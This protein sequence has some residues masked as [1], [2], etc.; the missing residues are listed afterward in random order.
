MATLPPMNKRRRTDSGY[1]RNR[2]AAAIGAKYA[3]KFPYSQYGT[4]RVPKGYA[5]A[6]IGESW[7]TAT[8]EQRAW[9]KANNYY[10]V[11]GFWRDTVWG[12][13]KKGAK[14]AWKPMA[15]AGLHAIGQGDLSRAI[16]LGAYQTGVATNA[17]V[18]PG[19]SMDVTNV[20]PSLEDDSGDIILSHKEMIANITL[21]P[22]TGQSP[23]NLQSF[24]INPGLQETFP[25]LSQIAQNFTKYKFEGLI[26]TYKPLSGEGGG[27]TNSLGKIVMATEYDP[28]AADF[29]NSTQMENS[30]Y[31]NS[32][33]PS[34]GAQ[35][36]VETA[37]SQGTSGIGMKYIR[38]GEVARDKT[39][40]DYGKFQF[41]TEAIMRES[42]QNT[43]TIIGEL[44][45]S[46]KVRLSV[47]NLYSTMLGYNIRNS[48]YD[49]VVDTNPTAATSTVT[50]VPWNV[51]PTSENVA[52]GKT[53][54][55]LKTT[56]SLKNVWSTDSY[57][58]L[59]G[60]TASQSMHTLK[61]EFPKE[62][63]LGVYRITIRQFIQDD[64][65][66]TT[67]Q[68]A[69]WIPYRGSFLAGD[70]KTR[71]CCPF[72]FVQNGILEDTASPISSANVY[73]L[74]EPI[75]PKQDG[76]GYPLL[77]QFEFN[78]C[79]LASREYRVQGTMNT[80]G[81]YRNEMISTTYVAINSP[82]ISIP[83]IVFTQ[84]QFREPGQTSGSAQQQ[85]WRPQ[86]DTS[87]LSLSQI[88]VMVEQVNAE[89]SNPLKY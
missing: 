83:T 2:R 53:V 38:T 51:S 61:I 46:Y 4:M 41:A 24:P 5:T 68:T 89:L 75:Q 7:R 45:V 63:L 11:G 22:G 47:A 67:N 42:G 78:N 13:I 19:N 15:K 64:L 88:S 81:T 31:S 85:G 58:G 52:L 48:Y 49:A 12:G 82:S 59:L 65:A 18:H 8:P 54:Q 30:Q 76:N 16:G 62:T 50:E 26:F 40:S 69:N 33:K 20:N 60:T 84:M 32:S 37:P 70:N 14:K 44:W 21:P 80:S 29:I 39:W 87:D 3:A 23:F 71:Y 10:G 56:I 36:G 86:I 17:L 73:D 74:H 34:L 6:Q 25:F 1:N 9:R 57:E 66:N 72:M 55:Q 79:A 77:S 35:H 27:S 28:S 43:T